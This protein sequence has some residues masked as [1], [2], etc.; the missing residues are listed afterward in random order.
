MAARPA[1]AGVGSSRGIRRSVG[2]GQIP[3]GETGDEERERRR[4]ESRRVPAAQPHHGR[5]E[6]RPRNRA[7][8]GDSR[9]PPQALG[10][11]FRARGVRDVRLHHT[12]G[13]AAYSLNQAGEKQRPH[14]ARRRKGEIGDRGDEQPDQDG[15]PAAVPVGE[16][17]PYWSHR[18]LGHREGRDQNTDQRGAG[19]E[20]GGIEG[21]EG[22]DHGQPH[23]IHEGGDEE[24]EEA[25]HGSISDPPRSQ[26][27]RT[28]LAMVERSAVED[29]PDDTGDEGLPDQAQPGEDRPRSA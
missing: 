23:H 1:H 29:Q 12:D 16:A 9:Q 3:P 22:H 28:G 25:S 19:P 7:E 26:S 11:L 17:P 6:R 13:A 8:T 10:S 2:L 20:L 21:K 15:R 14:R 24:D 4:G 18:E 5:S 27:N